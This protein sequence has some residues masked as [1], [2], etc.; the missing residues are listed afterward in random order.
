MKDLLITNW[1]EVANFMNDNADTFGVE[2]KIGKN[3]SITKAS[4]L[5]GITNLSNEQV[6]A[7]CDQFNLT[8]TQDN[9]ITDELVAENTE[10]VTITTSK[11]DEV[12]V[13]CMML[14]IAKLAYQRRRTYT[15]EQRA[16]FAESEAQGNPI[17][18]RPNG[19]EQLVPVLKFN[20]PDGST[21]N[22]YSSLF[23]YG[24]ITRQ[25]KA[26]E[27]MPIRVET[28]E[29]FDRVNRQGE[30]YSYYIGSVLE[31]ASPVLS[32][33]RKQIEDMNFRLSQMDEKGVE[34]FRQ[35]TRKDQVQSAV[36]EF[37]SLF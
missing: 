34:N 35:Q 19:E 26:G 29:R 2:F 18:E 32:N 21:V 28:L 6:S 3:G 7:L 31:S 14:P 1:K 5:E 24:G 23:Q 11:G 4:A 33:G 16:R 36:T 9:P 15:E 12:D 30:E 25:L 13:E 8:A 22:V 17:A 27:V 37:K 10:L 20:H